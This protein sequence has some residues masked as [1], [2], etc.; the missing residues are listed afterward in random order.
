MIDL[1]IELDRA[2][3]AESCKYHLILDET[4]INSQECG[5][6][7]YGEWFYDDR[8]KI[9]YFLVDLETGKI[10]CS[11][12]KRNIAR[13]IRSRKVTMDEILDIELFNITSFIYFEAK[14]KEANS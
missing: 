13:F 8:I 1:L 5:F 9:M 3:K 14:K 12:V 2:K 11:G 10:V 7:R 4:G 6:F